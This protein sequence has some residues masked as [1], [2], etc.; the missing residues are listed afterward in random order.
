VAF[1]NKAAKKEAP[2]SAL[3]VPRGRIARRAFLAGAAFAAAL[4]RP[5]LAPAA[6][7][8]SPVAAT[9]SFYD[10]LTRAMKGGS[11]IG[12]A[13]RRDL[14]TPA[15]LRFC[16]FPLMTR[17]M[18]GPQWTSLTP[19]QQQQVVSAFSDFS[20]ATYA[21]RFDDYSG[22]RFVIDP[23]STTTSNGVVVHTKLIKTDGD[24]VPID[25]LM[26]EADAGWQIIDVYL[27][28]TV[29]ELA[30]RRSEFSAVLRRGGADALVDVLQKKTAE[31]RS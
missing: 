9:Q 23:T 13:G 14:L 30:T 31:L 6:G 2:Y 1:A 11:H 21:S 8:E 19:A 7:A 12:F 26:R 20:A 18:V 25:Y 16:D 4:L 17:L 15:C 10:V 22:E 29:S 28:G 24:P 5:R 3:G 27:S